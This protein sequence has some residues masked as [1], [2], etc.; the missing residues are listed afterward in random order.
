[1]PTTVHLEQLKEI[2]QALGEKQ[3]LTPAQL[4]T[5]ASLRKLEPPSH[6]QTAA[7][8]AQ[9]NTN[10][11]ER[12]ERAWTEAEKVIARRSGDSLGIAKEFA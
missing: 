10:T 4:G 9:W 7:T 5:L 1:V 6:G 12:A 2:E 3:A 8:Q 11:R